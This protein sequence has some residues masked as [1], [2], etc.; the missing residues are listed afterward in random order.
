M[1]LPPVTD[2][3]EPD[4]EFRARATKAG[5]RWRIPITSCR[6]EA[7]LYSYDSLS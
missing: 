4:P 7:Q 5:A 6:S 2:K 1:A 3:P